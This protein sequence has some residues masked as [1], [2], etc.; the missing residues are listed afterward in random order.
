MTLFK[1]TSLR[2]R[3]NLFCMAINLIIII[4]IAAG[5][6]GIGTAGCPAGPC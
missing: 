2:F 1:R 4:C 3:L 6:P 5:S